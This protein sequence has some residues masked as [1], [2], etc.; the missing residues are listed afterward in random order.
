M[1]SFFNKLGGANSP[2]LFATLYSFDFATVRQVTANAVG[3]QA[4]LPNMTKP[5]TD[6][7]L[8]E[9][10]TSVFASLGTDWDT[11]IPSIPRPACASSAP[12]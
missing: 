12:R 10:T 11:A 1:S 2:N 5:D 9:K 4:Y 7:T 8:Q 6:R 3:N